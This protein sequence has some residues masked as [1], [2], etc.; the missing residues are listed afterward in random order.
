MQKI[1]EEG[2]NPSGFD[3]DANSS[4]VRKFEATNTESGMRELLC[5]VAAAYDKINVAHGK[6][7]FHCLVSTLCLSCSTRVSLLH[8]YF[9]CR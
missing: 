3:H 8:A 1:C 4:T 5:A 9:D 2:R 7:E 6:F